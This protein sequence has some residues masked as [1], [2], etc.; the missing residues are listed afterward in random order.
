MHYTQNFL[1]IRKRKY[2]IHISSLLLLLILFLI[3]SF[4]FSQ[5]DANS[6]L[7]GFLK[8]FTRVVIAYVLSFFI[9]FLLALLTNHSKSTEKVLLPLLD[10]L[11]SFPSFSILP[12]LI[13][14]LGR[15]DWV[16]IT[17]LVLVMIWPMLFTLLTSLKQRREDLEEAATVFG[18]KGWKRFRYITFPL[19]LP[20][21]ITGSVVAWGEAWE[22]VLGAEIIVSA[23]GVGSYLFS[24]SKGGNPQILIIGIFLLLTLLFLLNKFVWIPL[25]NRSTKFQND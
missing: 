5:V 10:A 24:Q 1:L 16:V 21:V 6:F 8:S 14:W 18:A 17:V 12:L 9:S 15:V 19:L 20:A 2:F 25:L 4:G 3:F 11:Q 22:T 23:S 7:S 13:V